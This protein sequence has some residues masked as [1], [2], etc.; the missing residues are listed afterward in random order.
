[1]SASAAIVPPFRPPWWCRNGHLQT[2]WPYFFRRWP[3][4]RYRRQ[5]LELPDGDFIDLDWYGD[6]HPPRPLV[7][8]LHGLE[9]SSCSPYARG[10]VTALD[11]EGLATVV[12]H[13]RGCSGEPNRLAR[14]YHA[15]ASEDLDLLIERLAGEHGGPLFVVGFSLGG[16]ILINWLGRQRPAQGWVRAA[17][18]VSVPYQLR[19]SAERMMRG[20]SR[21]YQHRLLSQMQRAYAR[22]FSRLRSPLGPLRLER[23]HGFIQFDDAVTAP[24]HGFAGVADY[25]RRCSARQYLPAILTPTLLVHARDDPLMSERVIPAS[26]ELGPGVDLELFD[27]GG[28]CGFV[29]GASPLR[30]QYWLD[31]RL[32]AWF[33]QQLDRAGAAPGPLR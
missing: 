28:H 21:I 14:G 20:V 33:R 1:M 17:A 27:H 15:G 12:M 22:K 26:R 11:R 23:L 8:I 5:R 6:T 32:P 24:L 19:A 4:P 31:Q 16:S 3:R 29:T 13:Q 30:P 7:M 9:G 18:A 25:Y 10:L 2:L